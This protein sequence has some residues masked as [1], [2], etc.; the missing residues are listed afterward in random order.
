VQGVT[1]DGVP[2][3][4]VIFEGVEMVR[5]MKVCVHVEDAKPYTSLG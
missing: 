2:V 3:H 4:C 1:V 5:E